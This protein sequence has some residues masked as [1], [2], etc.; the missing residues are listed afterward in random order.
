MELRKNYINYNSYYNDMEFDGKPYNKEKIQN[1]KKNIHNFNEMDFNNLDKYNNINSYSNKNKNHEYNTFFSNEL[2]SEKDS[3]EN[4]R[5]QNS[6]INNI[7]ENE[8][9]NIT[10]DNFYN[11]ANTFFNKDYLNLNSTDKVNV[12]ENINRSNKPY[13]KN[14]FSSINL[15]NNFDK[16]FND[17]YSINKKQKSEIDLKYNYYLNNLNK[18]IN[19]DNDNDKK[20]NENFIQ[21]NEQIQKLLEE[22]KNIE[23][24]N[25]KRLTELRVK[26]LSSIKTFDIIKEENNNQNFNLTSDMRVTQTERRNISKNNNYNTN[27][28]I[29]N[30]DSSL[31]NINNNI[32]KQSNSLNDILKTPNELSNNKNSPSLFK[33]RSILQNNYIDYTSNVFSVKQNQNEFESANKSNNK[34]NKSNNDINYSKS[35]NQSIHKIDNTISQ[36]LKEE[37]ENIINKNEEKNNVN[38]NIKN[39]NKNNNKIL[40]D[41][42]VNMSIYELSPKE[43]SNSQL[44]KTRQNTNNEFYFKYDDSIDEKRKIMEKNNSVDYV[45]SSSKYYNI[46][47]NVNNDF[48]NSKN[49]NINNDE[50]FKENIIQNKSD[51]IT[52]NNEN[53]NELNIQNINTND[54]FNK[55][56]NNNNNGNINI[57]L[58][59]NEK[60]KENDNIDNMNG[61]MNNY[62]KI[63]DNYNKLQLEYNS[64]KNEHL[65]LLE[66]YNKEKNNKNIDDEKTLFNEYII[67]ENN[68]LRT[69]NSNYEYILTPLINYINDINYH[70]NKKK[71]K[72]IDLIKIKQNI[73][74]TNITYNCI[75]ESPLYSFIQL[76]DNY[77]NIIVNDESLNN[78][79]NRSKSNP[80]KVYTYE[81]IMNDYKI[82]NDIF[83]KS[84]NNISNK[85]QKLKSLAVTPIHSKKMKN[86]KFFGDE[87]KIYNTE[88]YQNKRKGKITDTRTKKQI[89]DKILKKD[90]SLGK[91][92]KYH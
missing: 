19:N 85:S 35:Q 46:L 31:T 42:K 55:S 61:L 38:K 17:K 47:G 82:K 77:K 50:I 68:D 5:I 87:N 88:K 44:Y 58:N 39:I 8:L 15:Y 48:N 59:K 69:I 24:E 11:T 37:F 9:F 66:N 67:K 23:D 53:Q 30:K 54:Y 80:K 49:E 73:R 83:F 33:E 81:S 18:E 32:L 3:K 71:L 45:T 22:E 1:I 63:E 29:N 13:N 64:L 86:N 70:I 65:K 89:K 6:S 20:N 26:Y 91:K 90:T 52:N 34:N 60:Y 74:N 14:S 40:S 7:N 75:E 79:Y 76:L 72:N 36:S 4:I 16:N 12:E 2:H 56:M 92:K 21:E 78:I 57:L 51:D 62:K 27:I 28:N 43:K 25:L 41:A 10:R 84:K